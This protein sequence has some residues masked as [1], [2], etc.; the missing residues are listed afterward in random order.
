MW[1]G[2][3]PPSNHGG[4]EP[5]A[6]AFWP[7]V[8]RPA[9]LPLPAAIPRPTPMRFLP[10]PSARVGAGGLRPAGGRGASCLVSG[11]GVGDL[12][13]R[14]EEPDLTDHPAGGRVVRDDAGAADPVQTER[15]DGRPV[16]RDVTD[17]ALR[18][19]DLELSGHWPP[20]PSRPRAPAARRCGWSA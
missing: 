3:W 19:G 9:V 20:P 13:D 4:I 17:R 6:R 18:L 1:S 5:P 8:P 14:H 2:V 7:L 16:A 11:F 12:L 15:P 10:G